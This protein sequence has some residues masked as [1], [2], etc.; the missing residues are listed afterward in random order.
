LTCCRVECAPCQT[1]HC[2]CNRIH[3]QSRT[4]LG[5]HIACCSYSGSCSMQ[6]QHKADM[7]PR[8]HTSAVS[9]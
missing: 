6:A 4:H 7:K 1:A 8:T 9:V 2:C 3:S 5:T